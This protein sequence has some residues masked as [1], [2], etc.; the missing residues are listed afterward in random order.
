MTSPSLS[1]LVAERYGARGTDAHEPTAHGGRDV[2]RTLLGHRS[3]RDYSTS[4]IGDETLGLLLAAAQSAASSSNLQLWS[5]VAIEDPE[6]KRAVSE[7]AGR[8][9]HIVDCPLFLAWIADLHR[10]A[11]LAEARKIPHEGL[12]FLEMF[13]MAV[14]DAALAAQNAVVAAESLGLGTVYIGGLRNHPE[15]LAELL[16]LPPMSFAVF[17]LCVG[18]PDRKA[19]VV[20]PR[21]PQNVVL[22]R[23][24]YRASAPSDGIDEYDAVMEAFYARTGMGVAGGWSEHSAQR[25][26]SPAALRGRDRLSSAL[27]LLGFPLR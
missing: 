21:L 15:Q 23:E 9:R 10:T 14:V 3:V 5:V 20:K 16:R 17:G 11:V 6:R 13:V 8:Q 1:A 24:T 27:R 22:H 12:D 18:W 4:P 2:L 25:V 19:E 26:S 7:L